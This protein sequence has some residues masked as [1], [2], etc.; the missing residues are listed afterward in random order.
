[1][2]KPPNPQIIPQQTAP[3][4]MPQQAI[5]HQVSYTSRPE[6]SQTK[7]SSEAPGYSHPD[8]YV[9]EHARQLHQ[10]YLSIVGRMKEE[11]KETGSEGHS[12]RAVSTTSDSD[13]SNIHVACRDTACMSQTGNA[14]GE[15]S[16][17]PGASGKIPD[18]LS[19]FDKVAAGSSTCCPSSNLQKAYQYSPAFT[20]QSFDDFHRLLGKDLSPL[21]LSHEKYT[22]ASGEDMPMVPP[23]PPSIQNASL[24][25]AD[26]AG[27][28]SSR[29]QPITQ[30]Q[31]PPSQLFSTSKQMSN[32]QTNSNL[33]SGIEESKS[34][35]P[36]PFLVSKSGADSYNMFAQQSVFASSLHS[37]YQPQ[38]LMNA[39]QNNS[40]WQF[41]T[42]GDPN[43]APTCLHPGFNN[44]VSEPSN[45]SDMGTEDYE[46]AIGLSSG[47]GSGNE[48]AGSSNVSN[49]NSNDSDGSTLDTSRSQKKMR[50]SYDK[51]EAKVRSLNHSQADSTKQHTS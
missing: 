6:K 10:T 38:W 18:L 39:G 43:Q 17:G 20:S 9:S 51:P 16:A 23:M 3:Q 45:A 32:Q 12:T 35:Q 30:L 44:V 25:R 26:G 29:N 46:T 7:T 36:R 4:T 48:S 24:L 34:L 47:G 13:Q 41:S 11:T 1:V 22:V 27:S 42:L 50:I 37:T 33:P 8:E 21:V 2:T 40:D 14:M 15:A 28:P 19:G 31:N 49:N 5:F